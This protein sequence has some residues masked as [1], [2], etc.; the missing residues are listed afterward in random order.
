MCTANVIEK[1]SKMFK[2]DVSLFLTESGGYYLA[3]HL[4]WKYISNFEWLHWKGSPCSK[5][6]K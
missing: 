2:S 3:Y 6:Q 4:P 1:N 5:I